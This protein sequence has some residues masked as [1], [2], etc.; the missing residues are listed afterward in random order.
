MIK[1]L[2][3][4]DHELFEWIQLYMR[5]SMLD[6]FFLAFRDKNFWI[7][8]YVFLISWVSFNFGKN[9]WKVFVLCIMTVIITDQMNSSVFKK[10]FQR[11]RPC[12]ELYFKDQFVSA[13]P[14]SGGYSFP[15]SHATNHMGV[16]VMI[17]LICGRL[18]G[19][20]KWL[21]IFWAL[22]IGFSQIYV[23][24]HF[25]IDVLVGW[26]EGAFWALSLFL[27]SQYLNLFKIN[28]NQSL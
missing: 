23:G 26:L 1:Y 12:N 5:S 22:L 27:L 4:L 17:F 28:P 16:A 7:P 8:L 9:T 3:H 11:D 18:L 2:N 10:Y 24:V 21:F 20:L 15:S 19:R 6:P 25:P 14:C 13:L